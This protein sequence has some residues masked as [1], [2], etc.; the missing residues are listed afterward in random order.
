MTRSLGTMR[1]MLSRDRKMSLGGGDARVVPGAGASQG[2]GDLGVEA[3]EVLAVGGGLHLQHRE[4]RVPQGVADAVGAGIGQHQVGGGV[5][6]RL[7][8]VPG[9]FGQ[10]LEALLGAVL[11]A[12]GPAGSRCPGPAPRPPGWRRAPPPS[13]A[14]AEMVTSFTS[15]GNSPAA[16]TP[17]TISL[18]SEQPASAPQARIT[19]STRRAQ[20]PETAMQLHKFL[21]RFLSAS[22]GRPGGEPRWVLR[23]ENSLPRSGG[24]P[25]CTLS[26]PDVSTVP[27][28]YLT[29]PAARATIKRPRGTAFRPVREVWRCT[30]AVEGSALEIFLDFWKLSFQKWL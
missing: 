29:F 16:A 20:A 26:R 19:L 1:L 9:D 11:A 28:K 2:G 8:V 10:V 3:L 14:G 21:T 23:T 6:H 4:P 12:Q 25:Y 24:L 22:A 17:E 18:T 30:Q 27:T 7:G 5:D 13:G 15:T